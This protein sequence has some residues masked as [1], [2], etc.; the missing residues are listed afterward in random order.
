MNKDLM[1]LY[2]SLPTFQIKPNE[3]PQR[4]KADVGQISFNKAICKIGD[5]K[6]YVGE[7]IINSEI[8]HGRG[9]MFDNKSIYEG[10]F[11]MNQRSGIGRDITQEYVY[12]GY[13]DRKKN[14]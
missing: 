11:E 8:R 10:F 2:E 1:K 6:Y 7:W 9:I 13:H 4:L 12:Q 5:G 3:I 14:G